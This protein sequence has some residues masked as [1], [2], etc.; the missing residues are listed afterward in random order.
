MRKQTMI[1][2]SADRIERTKQVNKRMFDNTR[3]FLDALQVQYV[4]GQ[5][6]YKGEGEK[7]FVVASNNWQHIQHIKKHALEQLSQECVLVQ[8]GDGLSRLEYSNG[9][10]EVIGRL[11]EISSDEASNV[12]AYTVLN[13]RYYRAK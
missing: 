1:I 6:V 13:G 11:K 12:E 5:G 7:C 9:E 8:H 10:S 4:T 3:E 2:F